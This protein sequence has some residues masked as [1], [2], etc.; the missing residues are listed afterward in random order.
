MTIKGPKIR[1]RFIS[2]RMLAAGLVA[3]FTFAL[4][5]PAPPA[6]AAPT[7]TLSWDGNQSRLGDAVDHGDA[8]NLS[9]NGPVVGMTA[10][11]DAGGYWL[12]GSDG[13]V[14]SYGSAKFFGS[15]GSLKLNKP[16]VGMSPSPGSD[17]YRFVASDG[18]VFAYGNAPFYGS[19]GSLR[20]NQP[21][22]GMA[23]TPDGGG[24]W[25]VASDGGIFAYGNARF[26]GSTGSIHLNK[27][28][29]GMSPTP[30]GGGYWLVAS[31]GGIFA[32]G[33]AG[34]YG[35]TGSLNLNQPIV[36][37]ASTAD[38]RGYWL[39]AADGGV[40]AYGD[41]KFYGTGGAHGTITGMARTA[42]GNGYWFVSS[43]GA[44]VS[45][46][47]PTVHYPSAADSI[48][49]TSGYTFEYLA[50]G[51]AARWDPCTGPIHVSLSS[52]D[53]PN[54]GDVLLQN[55]LRELTEV[56]GLKFAYDGTTT[57][58]VSLTALQ[59]NAISVGWLNPSE[60]NG[61]DE[62]DGYTQVQWYYANRGA[63]M[64]SADVELLQASSESWY[65][66][67]A[68]VDGNYANVLKHELGHALG[69]WHDSDDSQVMYATSNPDITDYQA[70]DLQGL[71][72]VSASQGCVK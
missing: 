31:D 39:A 27:P 71:A 19:A 4:L 23:T 13:G 10:T 9:L 29:V 12:L 68:G 11:P 24:Y 37:M 18:G 69:L 26:F 1:P 63:R 2:R 52:Y 8:S 54:G 30:D 34:F 60:Y 65:N 28:I 42:S 61:G 44:V 32:Y 6:N 5:A 41:A 53:M 22:V 55:V 7:F 48:S 56:T 35:S 33:D 14:F 50:G 20:L 17:G 45:G 59:N 36:D 15:T 67:N 64:F 51:G 40:F 43:A 21:V 66:P 49:S 3:I 46:N 58:P 62:T 25:L 70:G 47:Y 16:V 38:G 72:D 57:N